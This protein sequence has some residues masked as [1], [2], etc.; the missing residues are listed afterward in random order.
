MNFYDRYKM[1]QTMEHGIFGPIKII[2]SKNSDQ[3]FR[4]IIY[5]KQM[6]LKSQVYVDLMKKQVTLLGKISHPHFLNIIDL[7]EDD[8]NYYVV[9]EL[10]KGGLLFKSLRSN[11]GFSDAQASSIAY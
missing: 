8:T 3:K 2:K 5:N 6:L 4:C 9:T 11:Q 1:G 7:F 10:T